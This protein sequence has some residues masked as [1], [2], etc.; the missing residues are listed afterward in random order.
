MNE[1]ASSVGL[2]YHLS[3]L[4]PTPLTCQFSLQTFLTKELHCGVW[5]ARR[6]SPPLGETWRKQ[7]W[8]ILPAPAQVLLHHSQ[9]ELGNLSLRKGVERWRKGK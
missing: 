3:F 1:M 5:G 2:F 9:S 7:V 8:G 6:F 4:P